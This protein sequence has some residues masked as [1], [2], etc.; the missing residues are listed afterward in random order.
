MDL[1]QEQA[2]AS[3]R[4]HARASGRRSRRRT[5]GW[6]LVT[7]IIAVGFIAGSSVAK[8][9]DPGMGVVAGLT[10]GTACTVIW[11]ISRLGT[12]R[13]S[14]QRLAILDGRFGELGDAVFAV[15]STASFDRFPPTESS[16]L[17]DYTHPWHGYQ[18]AVLG[19]AGIELR[20]LPRRGQ[21][22]GARLRY[23]NI[24]LI[25]DGTA[26]FSDFTERAILVR[27]RENG[28]QYELGI[29]PVQRESLMLTPVDEVEFQRI[30]SELVARAGA[31]C[32]ATPAGGAR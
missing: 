22:V 11:L 17:T 1:T 8:R 18:L 29:V 6:P 19:E 28:V 9:T 14:R 12:G 7:L 4:L 16:L 5:V 27:G 13:W 32:G 2:F 20:Q 31:T 24:E 25:A 23:S 21:S 10:V 3:L 30:L 26:T 15:R